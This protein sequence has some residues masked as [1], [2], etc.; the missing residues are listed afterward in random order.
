MKA[1]EVCENVDDQ[2]ASMTNDQK[3]DKDKVVANCDWIIK[4][5][6]SCEHLTEHVL[7]NS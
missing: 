4:E 7:F 5:F 6:Q 3:T 2:T 1:S